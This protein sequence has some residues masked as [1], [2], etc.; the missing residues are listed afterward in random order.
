M[1]LF[2]LMLM[3]KQVK[4]RSRS[5]LCP[6]QTKRRWRGCLR[7]RWS[8]KLK[9]KGLIFMA[10]Y[11]ETM[12][13]DAQQAGDL[14]TRI[15][16]L[17]NAA[18]QAATSAT[19]MIGASQGGGKG[20]PRFGDVAKV[21]RPPDVFEV[22][23][24]V[25]NSLWREQVLNWL[26]F[27]DSKY[28]EL[29]KDVEDLDLFDSMGAMQPDLKELSVKLYSILSS[30]LRGPALQIVRSC[31]GGKK[32]PDDLA[33]STVL[34]CI[35]APTRKHL[36]MVVDDDFS[37]KKLKDKLILLDKN[38]KSWWIK[39]NLASK[40][41]A[42]GWFG[43][44]YGGGG[45]GGYQKGGK[46]KGKNKGKKGGKSK[47]KGK[48][49]K[50]KGYGGNNNTCG[51]C[52]QVG[53]WGNEC[54]NRNT[55]SQVNDNQGQNAAACTPS[56]KTTSVGGAIPLRR[57]STRSGSSS[58]SAIRSNIRRVKLYNVATPPASS[59][60]I[61][62]L[63]SSNGEA[64]EWFSTSF[65]EVLTLDGDGEIEEPNTSW[66]DD[67]LFQWYDDCNHE[68]DKLQID[69]D[70]GVDWY[71]IRAVPSV[72]SQLIVLDSGAD[73]SLL[74]RSMCEKG[75]GKR[76]GRTVLQDA[77][78]VVQPNLNVREVSQI[79]LSLRMTLW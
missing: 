23:D 52:G 32:M 55:V 48:S 67:A 22:D 39:S 75:V 79:W 38:T 70:S 34:R 12:G 33:V 61:F 26:V 36:E 51:L 19:S 16:E 64:E 57:T 63:E 2:A 31:S 45:R 28:R 27:C 35:D 47:S 40:G 17:S 10:L 50:G 5:H 30:Y 77:Q 46:S 18:T 21:L 13:M 8:T 71:H 44:P 73:I 62:E 54:P 15:M 76:L 68:F 20:M 37:Y 7:Q 69:K 29:I 1:V 66:K 74:L 78:V 59:P 65:P 24:P 60:E 6:G 41:K 53:H 43:F 14:L 25:R 4:L 72:D 58:T 11:I 42:G 3:D 9:L 56:G 49:S